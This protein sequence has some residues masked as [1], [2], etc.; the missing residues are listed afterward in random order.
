MATDVDQIDEVLNKAL[1]GIANDF[2]NA[3]AKNAPVNTGRLK[4]SIRVSKVSPKEIEISLVEY[5]KYVE[6]GT[7]PHVITPKNGK[8]LKFKIG[9]KTV[10]AKRVNHPGTR[11]NPFI[12]NTINK[13][14][15]GIITKNFERQLS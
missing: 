3:L 1:M 8:A 2:R 14:L 12:R 11:P 9:S 6:W 4:N 13:E 7:P 10:F 5:A 15:S